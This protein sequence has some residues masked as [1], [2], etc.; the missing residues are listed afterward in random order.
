MKNDV[1]LF[2][3]ILVTGIAVFIFS[4]TSQQPGAAIKVVSGHDVLGV[5]N[6]ETEREIRIEENGL[7]VIAVS[8]G[9]AVMK[10]SDCPGGD[11]LKQDAVNRAG[12]SI[13]CLP[14]RVLISIEGQSEH[15]LDS[16]AY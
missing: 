8:N 4:T 6:L 5:Y 12:Q 9:S 11:C 13:V 10:E 15:E 1:I 16:I 14:N 2:I 3:V 7:N